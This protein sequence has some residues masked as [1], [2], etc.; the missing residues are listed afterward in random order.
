MKPALSTPQVPPNAHL[1][2]AHS[3][4]AYLNL[5]GKYLHLR[6]RIPEKFLYRKTL[7]EIRRKPGTCPRGSFVRHTMLKLEL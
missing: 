3:M 2:K 1:S 6:N 7:V 5:L 4:S